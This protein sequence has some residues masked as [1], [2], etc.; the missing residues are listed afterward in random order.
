M[1]DR[2]EISQAPDRPLLTER[3]AGC[4]D[5]VGGETLAHVL[6][7]M[8]YG[9]SVAA[10]GLAGGNTLTTTVIPFL[11]RGVNILGIDSVI[12]P[13]EERQRIWTRIGDIFDADALASI[14][15]EVALDDI[16]GQASQIL[17][18]LT[19]GRTVVRTRPIP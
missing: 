11:L 12:A 9:G 8:R 17:A 6:A 3:W 15:T 10:C 19:K 14:T 5:A 2:N 16:A 1:I 4:I 7:E 13:F 18:G